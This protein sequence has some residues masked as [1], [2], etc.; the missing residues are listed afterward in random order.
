VSPPF[1]KKMYIPW[2]RIQS[3]RCLACGMCCGVYRVRLRKQEWELIG[4]L[5]P[6]AITERNRGAYLRKIGGRCVFQKGR[7]CSLQP[8]GLKPLA[9]KLWPFV[10]FTAPVSEW[11]TEGWESLFIL[12]ERE[13]F[14]YVDTACKGINQG[15]PKELEKVI[16]ESV[17]IHNNPRV[18][19]CLT[20]SQG[21]L[22]YHEI[23]FPVDRASVYTR[24]KR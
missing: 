17:E 1:F 24:F 11:E 14:I 13:Y 16:A 18:R 10:V 2:R 20:T 21:E 7:L 19:Q 22:N 4:K 8:L 15:D 23:T 3:W 12:G 6:E 5:W 9:C